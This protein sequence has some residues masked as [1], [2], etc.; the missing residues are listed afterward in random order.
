MGKV[1]G[2]NRE[3]SVAHRAVQAERA[4]MHES[5]PRFSS[6]REQRLQMR[7]I[8]RDSREDGSHDQPGVDSSLP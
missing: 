3:K 6:R 1:L 5:R 2:E 8:I 7:K 4:A